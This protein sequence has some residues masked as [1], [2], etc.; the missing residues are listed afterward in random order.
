MD[1]LTKRIVARMRDERKQLAAEAVKLAKQRV[2]LRKQADPKLARTG[3]IFEALGDGAVPDSTER[4]LA[5][6]ARLA[7]IGR[8]L[9][10]VNARATEVSA[11]LAKLNSD[12]ELDRRVKHGKKLG[13]TDEPMIGVEAAR[14]VLLHAGRPLRIEEI[15]RD[16]LESGLLRLEGETPVQT[17]SAY[18]AKSAKKDDVFVRVD[19]GT[20]DLKERSGSTVA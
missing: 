7:T 5:D 2:R 9:S 12:G 8:Q 10:R 18:L 19:P 16:A 20:Y 15:T 3:R 13:A 4:A 17:I 14:V 1:S 6:M 11:A